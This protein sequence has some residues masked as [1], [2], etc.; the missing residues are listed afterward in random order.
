MA[1]DNKT[2]EYIKLRV[3][4]QDNSEV[5]FKVKMTTSLGKLKKSYAERQGVSAATLRFLFDGKRIND[6]ETPKQLEMED[7]DTIEVYQEQVGGC[8]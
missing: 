5:H 6:D 3:V 7:N 2:E 4:G 1:T 8:Y